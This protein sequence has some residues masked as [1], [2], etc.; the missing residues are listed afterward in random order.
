MRYSAL[1][2]ALILILLIS[3]ANNQLSPSTKA[4]GER[5]EQASVFVFMKRTDK[6]AVL[7]VKNYFSE[8]IFR[9]KLKSTHMDINSIKARGWEGYYPSGAL[10]INLRTEEKPIIPNKS[11]IILI[12]G[13]FD[14]PLLWVAY[15]I[16]GKQIATGESQLSKY[17]EAKEILTIVFS[18]KFVKRE[19]QLLDVEYKIAKVGLTDPFVCHG[20]KCGYVYLETDQNKLITIVVKLK[21]LAMG[22]TIDTSHFRV[23]MHGPRDKP[24]VDP[25][26]IKDKTVVNMIIQDE[27]IKGIIKDKNFEIHP[28]ALLV[29]DIETCKTHYCFAYILNAN[30]KSYLVIVDLTEISLVNV[31]K[32]REDKKAQILSDPELLAFDDDGR[33]PQEEKNKIVQQAIPKIKQLLEPFDGF[34]YESI[35]FNMTWAEHCSL[36]ANCP[37]QAYFLGGTVIAKIAGMDEIESYGL[38]ITYIREAEQLNLGLSRYVAEQIKEKA[39]ESSQKNELVQEFFAKYPDADLEHISYLH[40]SDVFRTRFSKTLGGYYNENP[41]FSFL[42]IEKVM[43]VSYGVPSSIPEHPRI[44]VYL[45]PVTYKV[46]GAIKR[47]S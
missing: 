23:I 14:Q 37:S 25:Y 34:A 41:A 36:Y 39:I 21:T 9:L 31:V 47:Y 44:V 16:N 24:I 42:P 28:D 12:S 19:L 30:D 20:E 27:R 13:R 46:L 3:T 15:D 35:R 38:R 45:E 8:S 7:A 22:I 29:Q 18:S 1:A 6:G 5:E 40:S 33:I 43:S 4:F 32:F 11:L 17:G 2:V 26:D 10:E